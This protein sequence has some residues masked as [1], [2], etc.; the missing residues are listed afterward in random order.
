MNIRRSI[1]FSL[2]IN[3]VIIAS[4]IQAC[5][6]QE[7]ILPMKPV[8]HKLLELNNNRDITTTSPP[9]INFDNVKQVLARKQVNNSTSS[10]AETETPLLIRG[11]PWDPR[12]N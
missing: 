4:P 1:M 3:G 9:S 2:G 7:E 12:G 10:L 5:D 11:N 8:Y 6:N